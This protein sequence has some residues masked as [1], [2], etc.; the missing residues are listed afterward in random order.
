[1]EKLMSDHI[2]MFAADMDGTCCFHADQHNFTIEMRFD[3]LCRV[4]DQQD[5]ARYLAH[6]FS[7]S[8]YNVFFAVETVRKLM[9]LRSSMIMV[10]ATGARPS[11]VHSRF[12]A[13]QFAHY[14]ILESGGV[15]YDE[16]LKPDPDWESH[17]SSDIHFLTEVKKQLI[18]EG[19]ELDNKGRSAAIRVRAVDNPGKSEHAFEELIATIELPQELKKTTNLGH[20]DIILSKAGKGNALAYLADQ[21]LIPTQN[22]LGM[23]DD[24]NDVTFLR[25]VG[26]PVVMR[27]GYPQ[28]LEHATKHGWRITSY[29]TIQGIHEILDEL[30]G[31]RSS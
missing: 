10:L 8:G 28:A 17:L 11:T 29:P 9:A 25:E 14:I 15:I 22:I 6:D 7:G 21:L 4:V 12:N 30:I 19:W 23:G 26:Y 31:V 2:Q 18:S 3:G 27:S 20:L 1:M 5:N 16:N 13:L 24:D